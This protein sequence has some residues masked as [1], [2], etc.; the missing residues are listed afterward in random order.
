[1]LL[2]QAQLD[3]LAGAEGAV[4]AAMVRQEQVVAEIDQAPEDYA[5]IHPLAEEARS[6]FDGAGQGRDTDADGLSDVAEV[7]L[8]EI[9]EEVVA[10]FQAF[11]PVV[12]DPA[13]PDAELVD[14][15]IAQLEEAAQRDP[16]LRNYIALIEAALADDEGDDTDG[17][18]IPDSV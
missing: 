16:I 3:R 11:D 9:S 10:Y 6:V 17:D 1:P 4:A 12:F 18:G 15:A 13:T 8:S 7:R 14:Q 5:F 2:V